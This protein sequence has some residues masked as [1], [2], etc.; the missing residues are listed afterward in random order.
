M[1]LALGGLMLEQHWLTLGPVERRSTVGAFGEVLALGG[2]SLPALALL[3]GLFVLYRHTT[4]AAAGGGVALAAALYLMLPLCKDFLTLYLLVE[5]ANMALYRLLAATTPPSRLEPVVMYFLIN[6]LGSL[7][8]LLGFGFL[9]W[10][11]GSLTFGEVGLLL[12]P[13]SAGLDLVAGTS[14]EVGLITILGALLLKLGLAP[15]HF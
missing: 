2:E 7:L 9:Y 8:L 10:G 11:S 13:S 12:L 5:A 6:L 14:L 15:F 1:A 3:V 4:P